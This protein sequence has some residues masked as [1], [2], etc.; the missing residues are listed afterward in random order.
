M[1]QIKK[2]K[3]INK[4][5][6]IIKLSII[7]VRGCGVNIFS[8]PEKTGVLPSPSGVSET[9]SVFI[10]PGAISAVAIASFAVVALL[11]TCAIYLSELPKH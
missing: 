6:I 7:M 2:L 9:P 3:N 10:R 4:L 1:K 5:I 8:F 11:L